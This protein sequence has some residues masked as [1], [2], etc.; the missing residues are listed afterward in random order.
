MFR[1]AVFT[2]EAAVAPSAG[3]VK[4]LTD[5][6][7]MDKSRSARLREHFQNENAPAEQ[8]ENKGGGALLLSF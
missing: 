4:R 8:Y 2:A 6:E 5:G 1:P 7:S 3:G